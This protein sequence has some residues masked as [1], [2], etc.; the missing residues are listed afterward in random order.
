MISSLRLCSKSTMR[1]TTTITPLVVRS[2][3]TPPTHEDDPYWPLI[4]AFNRHWAVVGR[5]N[6]VESKQYQAKRL[7]TQLWAA[8]NR[9]AHLQDWAKQGLTTAP[10]TSK[11][12]DAKFLDNGVFALPKTYHVWLDGSHEDDNLPFD[13]QIQL[14]TQKVAQLE[15]EIR[16]LDTR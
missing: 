8:K 9:L 5:A 6:Y 1:S 14:M 12:L 7:G 16:A 4:S 11:A 15:E 13:E 3:S 2:F 10:P